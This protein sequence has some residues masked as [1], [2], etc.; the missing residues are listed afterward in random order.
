MTVPATPRR[1]GPYAGNDVT[2]VFPFGFQVFG[3]DD[4]S[5]SL[6]TAAGNTSTLVR[7]TDYNVTLNPDQDSN[8]GGSI[9]YPISGSPL[10][11]GDT[12]VGV[13]AL[14]Y[15]QVTDLPPGGP[16]RALTIEQA[17][18][19]TVFQMQQLVEV[20]NRALVFSPSDATG[21]TLPP[22]SSRADRLL[23]F[24]SLGRILL[25]APVSGSAS[26]LALDLA[27]TV[28]STKGPALV[29]FNYALNYAAN[30]IGW[31]LKSNPINLAWFLVA[32]DDVADDTAKVQSALDYAHTTGRALYVPAPSVAYKITAQLNINYSAGNARGVLI[33]GESSG[34]YTGIGGSV[35][36]YTG[37]TGFCLSING[38]GSGVGGVNAGSPM[39][40][41]LRGLTFQGNA[42]CA[43]AVNVERAWFI[44]ILECQFHGFS[45]V[46]GGAITLNA[47]G[48]GNPFTG[49][50]DI[51]RCHFHSCGRDLWM[52][53]ATGG[54]INVVSFVGNKSLDGYQ[55]VVADWGA[56]IPF[57]NNIDVL[58]NSFQNPSG[59]IIY[60]SGAA[61]NWTVEYNRCEI[62][63]SSFTGHWFDFE[64]ATNRGISVNKNGFSGTLNAANQTFCRITNGIGIEFRQNEADNG[65][66]FDRFAVDLV[67]CTDVK[68]QP[69]HTVSGA[70]YPVRVN[71]YVIKTGEVND[72]WLQA[73]PTGSG[74][75]NG[76]A[77]GDGWPGG[78]VNTINTGQFSRVNGRVFVEIDTL[79]TTKSG[80]GGS[81]QIGLFPYSNAGGTFSF[82]AFTTGITGTQP[83]HFKM[84]NGSTFATLYDATDTAIASSAMSNGATVR[85]SFSYPTQ[86]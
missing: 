41:R 62:N 55:H 18:D 34:D 78:S 31:A 51:E 29:G 30:T 38:R 79:L 65:A 8:P 16:Y 28:S 21:S 24:D 82:S 59:N 81:V 43:G 26:A 77:T 49:D 74:K 2:T 68:V 50:V 53:G 63:G 47:S 83:F 76:I 86:D 42:T 61:Q 56:G 17:F 44:D 10:A 85:C 73:L 60:S 48:T 66:L 54:S 33:Y 64:G 84:T 20:L 58:F 71:N 11:T 39:G 13:G 3:V 1:A 9:A 57:T 4:V 23:G 32:G 6:T 36:H 46:T 14:P 5:W 22:A 27:N 69:A 45:S 7:G 37:T 70:P 75:F 35:F 72:Q 12:L 80:S 67:T 19:R 40:V 25:S 52:T 15:D